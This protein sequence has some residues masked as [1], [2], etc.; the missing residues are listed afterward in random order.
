MRNEERK[1]PAR[2]KNSPFASRTVVNSLRVIRRPKDKL[3][4]PIRR[5]DHPVES[6]ARVA[7]R[8]SQTWRQRAGKNQSHTHTRSPSVFCVNHGG[9]TNT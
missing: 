8:D 7:A 6:R 9:E 3:K 4:S 5:R 1:I 2:K